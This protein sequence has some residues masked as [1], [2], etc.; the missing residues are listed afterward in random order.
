MA[1]AAWPLIMLIGE[2][3]IANRVKSRSRRV[4]DMPPD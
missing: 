3:S 4:S 2:K 1:I